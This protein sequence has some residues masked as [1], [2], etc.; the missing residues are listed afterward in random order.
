MKEK[1]ILFSGPMV[2]AILEGRK[3]QTRRAFN[4]REASLFSAA[5]ALGEISDFLNEPQLGENDLG[6]VLD[7][8]PYGKVGDRL[9]VRETWQG[10]RQVNPEYD[11]W[12]AMDSPK[13][14]HRYSFAPV[15][16]ADEKNLPEKW[17]PAIHM[18]REFSR[19]TLEITGVRIE[20]LN[21]ISE[22]DAISEG[23]ELRQGPERYPMWK[24]YN[25]TN[26]R[27][28]CPIESF[29]SLWE[30]INGAGSWSANPWV[31]VIEF[32]RAA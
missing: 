15:Y 6:Y 3:T 16:R 26:M 27:V 9:W 23:I 30:S 11:E 28:S 32:R 22:R 12:E 8:C 29:R 17:L 1:P 19:I 31:W 5:V 13:D 4:D 14:R 20:R 18:P 2:R 24:L 25:E 10:Y 21:E 7:F